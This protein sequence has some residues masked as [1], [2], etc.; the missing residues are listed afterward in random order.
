M[1][2]HPL[3]YCE[4]RQK[5]HSGSVLLERNYNFKIKFQFS[6]VIPT[7]IHLNIS[8]PTTPRSPIQWED[9]RRTEDMKTTNMY[10]DVRGSHDTDHQSSTSI[11]I[12]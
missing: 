2:D 3:R 11:W 8:L 1:G 5:V 6:I 4:F 10:D 9:K 12:A 7:Q